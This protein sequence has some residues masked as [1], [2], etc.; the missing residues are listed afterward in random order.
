MNSTK[1]KKGLIAL[2]LFLVFCGTIFLLRYSVLTASREVICGLEEHTHSAECYE[3][4]TNEDDTS[5]EVLIC[6][7]EEHVHEDACY[8]QEMPESETQSEE[9][10][11]TQTAADDTQQETKK[12]VREAES[13]SKT[14]EE[15]EKYFRITDKEFW[16]YITD[17]QVQ[18][19]KNDKWADLSEDI[20]IDTDILLTINYDYINPGDLLENNGKIYI[21]FPNIFKGEELE[22][23]VKSTDGKTIGSVEV[24]EDHAL[25][26][27]KTEWLQAQEEAGGKVNGTVPIVVTGI[28]AE[29]AENLNDKGTNDFNIGKFDFEIDYEDD[30]ICKLADM[31]VKKSVSKT[32]ELNDEGAFLTYTLTASLPDD[33]PVDKVSFM[34]VVDAFTANEKYID[35]Y[36]GIPEKLTDTSDV[37][38]VKETSSSDATSQVQLNEDGTLIWM[39]GD[40]EKGETRTLTYKVKLTSDYVTGIS[41]RDITNTATLYSGSYERQSV[42]C[43]FTPKM[44]V[45]VSKESAGYNPVTATIDY[46]VTIQ[47]KS[48]NSYPLTQILLEDKLSCSNVKYLSYIEKS[49]QIDGKDLTEDASLSIDEE[50]VSFSLQVNKLKPNQTV[51]ITYSVQVDVRLMSTSNETI[52]ITNNA[53]V[54][55]D[56]S[57]TILGKANH[58]SSIPA[59]VW[60]RKMASQEV[61]EDTPV[62]MDGN[63][64]SSAN[65]KSDVTSFVVPKGATQYIVVVNEAADWNLS[66]ATFKDAFTP[67]Y[68]AFSGYVKVEAFDVGSVDTSLSTSEVCD[69][70]SDPVRTAWLKIE[71]N[72]T[73]ATSMSFTPAQ[74]GF[75]NKAQAYKLTYYAVPCGDLDNLSQTSVTNEFTVSGKV[76]T[77][78]GYTGEGAGELDIPEIKVTASQIVSGGI[79]FTA[80]KTGWYFERNGTWPKGE[81]Y[82]IIKVDGT[83]Q[84]GSQIIDMPVTSGTGIFK[85]SFWDDSCVGVYRGSLDGLVAADGS[86][87]T[88]LS[89]CTNLAYLQGLGLSKLT[90]G[91][92]YAVSRQGRYQYTVTFEKDISLGVDESIYIIL[93]SEPDSALSI[94]SMEMYK[95]TLYTRAPGGT[96]I[97]QNTATVF[98]TGHDILYKRDMGNYQYD[99]L[100]DSFVYDSTSYSRATMHLDKDQIRATGS[101]SY[102]EWMIRI[103]WFANLDGTY[104]FTE[105]LPSGTE[106]SYMKIFGIAE[107]YFKEGQLIQSL[108][109]PELEND[110]D[111]ERQDV[112]SYPYRMV[113]DTTYTQKNTKVTII[114]YYNK[115]TNQVRFALDNFYSIENPEKPADAW[116][117]GDVEVQIVVR[118]NNEDQLLSSVAT[119]QSY[120]NYVTAVDSMKRTE[121]ASSTITVNKTTL[122]KE[123]EQTGNYNKYNYTLDINPLAED[124]NGKST[125]TIQDE[126]EDPLVLDASSI[127]VYYKKANGTYAQLDDDDW[128][129]QVSKSGTSTKLTLIVP[130]KKCLQIR[131]STSINAPPFTDTAISNKAYFDG[132]STKG[133]VL[134]TTVS[135]KQLTATAGAEVKPYLSLSKYDA[136]EMKLLEGATF[137]LQAGTFEDGQF[138]ASDAQAMTVTATKDGSDIVYKSSDLDYGIVYKLVESEAPS[139]YVL[140]TTPVYFVFAKNNGTSTDPDFETY[141]DLPDSVTV[142]Y[143][144]IYELQ[145]YNSRPQ[146]EFSVQFLGKD[147]TACDPLPGTYKFGL[148]TTPNPTVNSKPVATIE[149]VYRQGEPSP[150]DSLI[151]SNLQAGTYSVF[152]LDDDGKPITTN[153][154]T[155]TISKTFFMVTSTSNKNIALSHSNSK[156]TVITNRVNQFSLVNTGSSGLD[157][158]YSSGIALMVLAIGC[159]WIYKRLSNRKLNNIEK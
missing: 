2:S 112:T 113:K 125:L 12:T 69:S 5:E 118:V 58:T 158:V 48:D 66:Q 127:Q 98:G 95:N 147:G 99:S 107:A 68:L 93:K 55:E 149:V 151:F 76:Y 59:K 105:Q 131:Y 13:D 103:D 110:P 140:D 137:T 90:Q 65:T 145:M 23:D 30:L 51:V 14:E 60:N 49:F 29:I 141:D 116:S 9:S 81:I 150:F 74:L 100:S 64:Y 22:F 77:P 63:V 15:E 54:K 75:S 3:V 41:D 144:T 57:K 47:A 11:E 143:S 19:L 50:A 46:T 43:D 104:Q 159:A 4:I 18:Q 126:M 35:S 86:E 33:L 16:G 83:L 142:V 84:R 8:K 21:E 62:T 109:I 7:K 92:E 73:D 102:M 135:Y 79:D 134:S 133:V 6:E 39:L 120:T 153:Y 24:F 119:K 128:S 130:N 122:T 96:S 115:K 32:V 20:P 136:N 67:A 123:V 91:N 1:E 38:D 52:L 154:S 132:Y 10:S 26:T 114:T 89:Q 94:T 146:I 17:V 155:N 87:L 156:G 139:G 88:D 72:G 82:W 121:T 34:Q 27:M 56:A 28:W 42:E 101:G 97:E 129:V 36:V 31:S 148:Y 138:V 85:H 108:E 40:M 61:P 111:W 117:Y 80:E 53:N 44:E 78:D 124:L 37:K 71:G 106:F 152:E 25:V 45:N 157:L 70:L